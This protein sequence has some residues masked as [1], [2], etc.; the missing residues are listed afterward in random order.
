MIRLHRLGIVKVDSA[1]RGLWRSAAV[2]CCVLVLAP[3]PILA[4]DSATF[5]PPPRVSDAVLYQPSPTPDRIVL[6]WTGDPSTSQSVTWRTSTDVSRAFAEI[7]VAEADPGFKDRARRVEA[8]TRAFVSNLSKCHVHNARF[9][10][11]EPA[12]KYA[13]R[14]GDGANW[15]EWFHFRTAPAADSTDP[16]SFI[17][18]GD[19]QN[20][21]RSMWSRV[22]R[23][24]W[25]DAPR[26]AF[27][28][29]AG[30]LINI[31]EN[32]NE[33]GEWFAAGGWLNAMVPV[34]AAPG[35]HEYASLKR[36]DGSRERWLTRHWGVQW[37]FP[38]NGP[39]GLENSVHYVDY[40]NVRIVALNSNEG[41]A[42]QAAWLDRVLSENDRTWTV[43]T[44]H[45]PIFSMAR[46]R[47]NASL[48]QQ[49]KP[50]FDRHSVDLVLTGHDHTY[51]R[52]ALLL[53][54][55]NAPTGTNWR[56]TPTGTVYVVSVSGPKMYELEPKSQA[57]I[58]RVAENTQLYQIITVEGPVLRYESRT[59]VGEV[60]DAFTLQKRDGQ[61]NKMTEQ[62]PDTPE[63]RRSRNAQ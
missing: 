24:A 62:V 46:D 47:D 34:I 10:D 37:A 2:L 53:P 59:A 8:S 4:H 48:R 43:L 57:E 9:D 19:S 25:L 21:V 61:P 26:A 52:T 3:A 22:L 50:V 33:W 60:Y 45:H 17:Y 49:W 1:R 51:G 54:E 11:L 30:D 12:T 32:D 20:D 38:D 29:H 6:T 7:A 27:M 55:S 23:E 28:V 16:F 31:A 18:F 42:E 44:F 63:R 40:Q 14:V 5:A 15:S 13:Y 36:E 35:N 58:Q 41:Q 56:A 39:E